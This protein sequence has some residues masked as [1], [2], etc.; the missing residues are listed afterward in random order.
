MSRMRVELRRDRGEEAAA[1]E[2]TALDVREEGIAERPQ[3]LERICDVGRRLEDLGVEDLLRGV[4][5]R[6]LKLF[7][8]AEVCVEAALAHPDVG[9]EVADRDALETVDRGEVRCGS[10]DRLTAP[11]PVGARPAC[12]GRG[13]RLTR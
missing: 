5:G 12:C 9:G 3:T 1:R 4:D 6:E 11:F 10:K 13:H 2:D 8:G 7:L